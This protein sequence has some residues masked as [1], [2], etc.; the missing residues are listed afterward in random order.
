MHLVYS[1]QYLYNH[2]FQFLRGITVVPREIQDNGYAKFWGLNTV[3]YSL[4]ENGEWGQYLTA[5]S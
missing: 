3:H 5:S 4:C 2:S 1:P